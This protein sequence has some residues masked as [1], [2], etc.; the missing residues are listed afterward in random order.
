MSTLVIREQPSTKPIKLLWLNAVT[1]T[2]YNAAFAEMIKSVKLPN[3]TVDIASLDLPGINLTNLEW[4]AFEAKIWHPVTWIAYWAGKNGYDGYC[5]PCFYDTALQEAREVLG[6]TIVSA[7]CEASL[8]A[9][10]GLCNKF[11]VII[12]VDKW[13]NQMRN[14]IHDYGYGKRLVSFITIGL[15]VDDLQKDKKDTEAKIRKAVEKAIADGAEGVILGCTIEFGFY[16]VLQEEYD[17]PVIDAAFACYKDMEYKAMNKMQFGWSP[18][19]KGSME[20][21][22]QKRIDDSGIYAGEPP[23]GEITTVPAK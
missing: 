15:H 14:L 2:A 10:T 20:P 12:G 5:I 6:K 9:I 19:R 23:I 21:P 17:I 11:S 8:Q 22:S 4:R 13:E 18:S 1:T 16:Q 7:P 3:A